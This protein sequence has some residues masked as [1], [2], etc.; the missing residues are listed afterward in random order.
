MT[1]FFVGLIFT[2]GVFFIILLL[3]FVYIFQDKRSGIKAFLFKALLII[4]VILIISELFSSFC[5]Y[6]KKAP[7]LGE[8]LLKFHW[9]TGVVFF[10]IFYF[11]ANAHLNNIENMT[12]IECF[13]KRKISKIL[14]IV[15]LIVSIVF[16][17]VQFGELDYHALSY[18]PG[19]PAYIVFG[20]ATIIVIILFFEYLFKKNKTKNQMIFMLVFLS[21]PVYDVVLQ[22]VWINVAFSPTFIAFIL[23]GAYFLLENPD[24]YVAN[25]LEKTKKE[26][27]T[28]NNHRKKIIGQKSKNVVNEL[29]GVVNSNYNVINNNNLEQSKQILSN[30]I[31]SITDLVFD[32]ENIFNM[33]IINENRS[34]IEEYDYD[35]ILLLSKLYNFSLNKA[36]NKNI[37]VSFDID[38]FLPITLKGNKFIVY[39]ILLYSMYVSLNNTNEGKVS[40]KIKCD[41]TNNQVILNIN[42]TDNGIPFSND[43]INQINADYTNIVDDSLIENYIIIKQ[44]ISYLNGRFNV[45]PNNT[46]GNTI[47]MSFV[48]NI[49]NSTII[50]E[51]KP[52]E[53]NYNLDFNG[54]KILIID[55][56]PEALI[57]IIKKYNI[58]YESSLSYD[59]G[60]NKLKIDNTFT[61]VLLNIDLVQNN[62]DVVNAIK[63]V[64]VDHPGIK[65]RIIALSSN[66]LITT[67]TQIFKEGFD[68]YIMK[69]YNKYD[70]DEMIKKI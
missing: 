42:I 58:N 44:Y 38:Q 12:K 6:D 63:L 20:Y 24:L 11:Y 57:R 3:N 35:S 51:F 28:F 66:M 19:L 31:D 30:N 46:I 2:I 29:Y 59:E 43:I 10:Y 68:C 32:V 64:M 18:L 27:E 33:L 16:F 8:I 55:D 65:N 47:S 54:R 14:T 62:N 69:P 53:I 40:L 34:V 25:A 9:Y 45:I 1:D 60:I 21:A 52:Y 17:V 26:L 70:F 13:W 36:K 49:S 50:G 56:Q 48:Q 23:M 39:Q 5:L 22:V 67:R 61:T 4:D 37:E 15:T 7:V 41:F